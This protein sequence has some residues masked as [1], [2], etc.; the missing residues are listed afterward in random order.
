MSFSKV[1]GR[2]RSKFPSK[3]KP[4]H[5]G[6]ESQFRDPGRMMVLID[7]PGTLLDMVELL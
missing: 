6:V 4:S 5:V 7:R 1:A 2:S 3:N